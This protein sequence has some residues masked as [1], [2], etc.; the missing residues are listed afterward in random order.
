MKQL[1]RLRPDRTREPRV[2]VPQRH[3]S[4]AG[5]QVDVLSTLGVDNA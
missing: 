1:L 5:E 4:D 3:D 2:R